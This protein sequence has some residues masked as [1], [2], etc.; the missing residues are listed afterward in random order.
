MIHSFCLLTSLELVLIL[1]CSLLYFHSNIMNSLKR[2]ILINVRAINIVLK[3]PNS[4]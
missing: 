1:N 3:K 4:V 2:F